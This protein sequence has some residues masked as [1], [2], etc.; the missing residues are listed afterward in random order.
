MGLLLRGYL[1]YPFI[2]YPVAR[3]MNQ[4]NTEHGADDDVGSGSLGSPPSNTHIPEKHDIPRCQV[5]DFSFVANFLIV[6]S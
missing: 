1:S 6:K 2:I 5:V 3:V 4:I